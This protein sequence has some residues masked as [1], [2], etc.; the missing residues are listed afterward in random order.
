MSVNMP[1][2]DKDNDAARWLH[3]LRNEVNT[4]N[5]ACS[6]AYALLERGEHGR[7]AQN[8]QRALDAFTRSSRLLAEPPG[9]L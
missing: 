4:A 3:S 1:G 6:A 9:G 5:M 2:E 8:L 7:A